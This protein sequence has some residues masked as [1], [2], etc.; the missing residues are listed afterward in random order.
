[1]TVMLLPSVEYL[2][3]CFDY[4]PRTGELRWRKRPLEHFATKGAWATLNTRDAGKSAGYIHSQG[5]QYVFVAGSK[6]K[7]HRIIWK[8]VTGEEPP[9]T[10]DH[11]DGDPSNNRWNNLR[12][13][14]M[15]EQSRN[16]R[17][18]KDNKSGFRGI[19]RRDK[20]WRASIIDKGISRY[21][22]SFA[23][24]EEASAAHEGAARVLH[25]EFYRK[26]KRK[27]S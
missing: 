19:R 27:Q 22:G 11:R 4:N 2:R 24:P 8:L 15:L 17:V 12:P 26:P 1:M 13:A 21:L 20:R 14:T 7:A 3:V 23:T 18:R 5:C 6:Y 9:G 25:G 16:S 10:I